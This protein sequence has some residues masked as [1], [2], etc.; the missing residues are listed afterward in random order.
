[1]AESECPFHGLAWAHVGAWAAVLAAVVIGAVVVGVFWRRPRRRPRKKTPV[2]EGEVR[3]EG[4]LDAVV[5]GAGVAGS[6]LA[7]TLGKVVLSFR[8]LN[9]FV[10]T[11]CI[12]VITLMWIPRR[13]N[14]A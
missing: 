13:D 10:I 8:L 14:A 2:V 6:A 12:R 9:V 7:Y 5:V 11:R 3:R 4:A 1:M